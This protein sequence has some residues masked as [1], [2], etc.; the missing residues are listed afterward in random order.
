M[1][2]ST[3]IVIGATGLIGNS[4]VKQ[5][6]NDSSFSKITILVRTWD[7][8]SHPK[9]EVIPVNFNN[10]DELRRKLPI[11]KAI[12][13][14]IGT[15][16]KKV[17]GDKDAYRKIDFDIPVNIAQLGIE[18]GYRQYLLVSAVGANSQSSNFYLRLKGQVEEAICKL[19]FESI[20]IFRPSVLIGNRKENRI[21]ERI[22]IALVKIF[23]FLLT[24]KRSIYKAIHADNVARA[25]LVSAT[26]N[27]KGITINH[28]DEI[29]I[30]A[31]PNL[32]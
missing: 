28:Y 13:C 25:M 5:L 30:M 3:A 10:L 26:L 14:C 23:S 8:F 22:G 6:L 24:G 19:P 7:D 31:S 1:N 4:L 16:Q 2:E 9:L 11:G 12:F 32:G 27:K 15:T 18:K 29:M 20:T 17:K 21:G